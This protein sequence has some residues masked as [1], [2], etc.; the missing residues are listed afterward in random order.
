MVEGKVQCSH[1]SNAHQACKTCEYFH[2]T[3]TLRRRR[4]HP[5]SKISKDVPSVR[6]ENDDEVKSVHPRPEVSSPSHPL[7]LYHDL[8][9]VYDREDDLESIQHIDVPLRHPMVLYIDVHRERERE[10]ESQAERQAGSQAARHLGSQ[11]A[12][13]PGSQAARQ[14]GLAPDAIRQILTSTVAMMKLSKRVS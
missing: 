10:K 8:K 4:I 6:D 1:P 11:P 2:N 9:G 14:P 7:Q 5:L 3:Q 13:Q 12:R